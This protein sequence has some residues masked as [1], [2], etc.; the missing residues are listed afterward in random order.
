MDADQR[1]N[2]VPVHVRGEDGAW[3]AIDLD[4]SQHPEWFAGGHG[5]YS[6]PRD[7][8]AF[9]RM[10]LGGGALGDARI[11]EQSTVDAAFQNQIGDIDFPAAIS[12]ADPVAS[13]DVNL[14]TGWKWG[15]GLLR[16][17]E[18]LP[19]MRSAGSGA[20]AGIFNTHFWVDPATRV[21][22]AVY[23]QTLPFAEPRVFQMYVDFEMALYASL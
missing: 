7:Y 23:T 8:L 19:G 22:G 2:S 18:S 1:A 12:T 14:G 3:T 4:W 10:L 21:T 9:Q 17:T 15:L 16:N 13:G 5:L 20:W 6:T 11:L